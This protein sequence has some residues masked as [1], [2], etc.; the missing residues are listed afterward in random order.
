VHAAVVDHHL[1]LLLLLLPLRPL[2]LLPLLLLPLLLLAMLLLAMLL[3]LLLLL[4]LW[5]PFMFE[6]DTRPPTTWFLR[7]LL[8]F[9]TNPAVFFS[10]FFSYCSRGFS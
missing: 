3:L 10:M 5:P 2:L 9:L 4:M 8:P 1:P 7:M 6:N